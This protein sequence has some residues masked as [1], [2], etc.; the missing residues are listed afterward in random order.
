MHTMLTGTRTGYSET[1]VIEG[2]EG[3]IVCNTSKWTEEPVLILWYRGES[4]VPI[5]T[6]DGRNSSSLQKA[7]QIPSSEFEGRAAFDPL[8]HPPTLMIKA[9]FREDDNEYRC[10]CDF[11]TSRTQNFLVNLTV[12]GMFLVSCLCDTCSLF[13]S[14]R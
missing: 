3:G 4:G 14:G 5:Y 1:D 2:K 12:I 10:R 8:H 6:V 11:R 9:L 13:S 7:Q